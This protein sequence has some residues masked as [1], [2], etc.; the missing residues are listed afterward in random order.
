MIAV[1]GDARNR[2]SIRLHE[3][4]GF[5]TCGFFP[6]AGMRPTPDGGE[7]E[8]DVVLLQRSLVAGKEAGRA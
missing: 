8:L 6:G 5:E 1:V 7:V 4:L 2:A 3:S